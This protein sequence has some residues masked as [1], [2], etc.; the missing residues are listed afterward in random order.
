MKAKEYR[1]IVEQNIKTAAGRQQEQ[2]LELNM[3][4][5]V[6][7]QA[8]ETQSALLNESDA[9]MIE[10]LVKDK[11]AHQDIRAAAVARLGFGDDARVDL[12]QL[13]DMLNDP[14][15]ASEVKLQAIMKLEAASFER[16]DF[17]E[18]RPQY[19]AVLRSC[20]DSR[21]EDLLLTVLDVLSSNKD[22]HVQETLLGWLN[23]PAECPISLAIVLQLLGNDIHSGIYAAAKKVLN[24]TSDEEVRIEAMRLL[25]SDGDSQ[26]YFKSVLL[27]QKESVDVRRLAASACKSLAPD[28]FR[29]DALSIIE[30]ED[31][32]DSLRATALTGL[33]HSPEF[34]AD[35][36]LRQ[37][38][39]TVC[40]NS[41]SEYIT[42][43]ADK[44]LT[45]TEKQKMNQSYY[46]E[47]PTE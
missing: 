21:D 8:L 13:I 33:A 5:N 47:E 37:S 1:R 31:E 39:Q 44:H 25:A 41:T 23:N 35:D 30:D 43:M 12:E 20:L 38:V 32:N 10:G 27:D 2:Q 26:A 46:Y 3:Q 34:L 24:D 40:D 18:L 4:S 36:T 45:R 15:E 11:S 29:E 16:I 9:Q 6:L 19:F 7:S 28:Q 22:P 42:V 14:D 17:V